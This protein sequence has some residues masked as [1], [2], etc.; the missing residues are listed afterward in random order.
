MTAQIY[1]NIAPSAAPFD[2][3]YLAVYE[4]NKTQNRRDFR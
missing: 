4:K 3:L 2:S 1:H